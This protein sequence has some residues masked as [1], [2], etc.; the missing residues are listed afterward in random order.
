MKININKVNST[1]AN[2]DFNLCL[3][4]KPTEEI[5]DWI[6]YHKFKTE[7]SK[8]YTNI[9]IPEDIN[10]NEIFDNYNF[11]FYFDGFSPNLNKH[12]HLGHLSNL[13]I[14]KA[15]QN[16]GITN[17]TIAIL[18]D[19]LSGE[20]NKEDALNKYKE[21]LSKYNYKLSDIYYASEQVLIKNLLI[22]GEGEYLGTKIF[23]LGNE[24]IVGIKSDGKSTYFYQDV[25]LQQVLNAPTLYLTGSEQNN[26]F[27][28]LKSIFGHIDHKGLGLVMVNGKK[29][30]SSEG[31]VYFAD[32]ILKL[33]SD[34][35]PDEKLS[36]NVLAGSIL[37]YSISTVKNIDIEQLSNVKNS[38]GLYVSYTLAR[39][40]SAGIE[41]IGNK[42]FHDK[43]LK[44]LYYKSKVMIEPN[45]LFNGLVELCK[46]INN[47]YTTHIIKDNT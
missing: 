29:M 11:Y 14:A 45:V 8:N 28:A 4:N 12:L 42:E 18:G 24:K 22:E 39:M 27:S 23:D 41:K 33:I 37:K 13:F 36:Y 9:I 43:K 6:S 32:D 17:K 25:A 34:K 20:V 2:M 31:N 10:F 44:Y 38:Y 46:K 47:L 5:S 40:F 30:S 1:P 26:H 15:I 19:T 7:A 16:L 21:Y 3:F 35:F